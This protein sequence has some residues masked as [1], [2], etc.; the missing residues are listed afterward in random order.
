MSAA[1]F[2]QV[3]D[4]FYDT[5]AEVV[6][7]NEGSIDKFVGDEL[8]A[9]FMPMLAGEQHAA[10][11]LDAA[12]ALLRATGHG[13]PGGP[14]I[15]LGAGVHSGIAWIGAVGEGSHSQITA[16][17]DNVNITARLASAV[18]AGEI[19]VTVAAAEAAQLTDTGLEHRQLELKGK[20]QPTEV[21]VLGV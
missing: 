11:A 5:A 9:L 14:W 1:A 13:D 20:S 8:V 4:R 15:S 10:R 7:A 18:A 21:L 19:L 17:G 2:R 12:R 3:L 6:I 16:V